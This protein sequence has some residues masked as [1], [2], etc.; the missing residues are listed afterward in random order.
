M[1]NIKERMPDAGIGMDVIAG[2]PGETEEDFEETCRLLESIGIYYLHAFP[3]SAR[4]GTCS[5]AMNGRVAEP[6]KKERVRKL[7][8]LDADMRLAFYKRFL[9][10]VLSIIP[11][12][13]LHK[14]LYMKGFSGNYIPVCI[15]YQKNLENKLVKVKI[16]GIDDGLVLGEVN[17]V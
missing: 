12:G 10:S 1:E 7:K 9:D 13:K 4:R 2:F 3:Y 6:V 11:E 14:G 16:N 15:P 5:F 8:K 17:N